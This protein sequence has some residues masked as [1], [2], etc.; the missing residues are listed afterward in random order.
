M[1]K[2]F[3]I[4]A[5]AIIAFVGTLITILGFIK[6][7]LG[8]NFNEPYSINV[9][10]NSSTTI[11]KGE[12]IYPEDKEYAKV[13][14]NLNKSTKSSLLTLLLKT[15]SVKYNI[16]YD[17]DKY[18]V[19]DTEMKTKNLV[20]ELIYNKLQ[21]IVVYEGKNTRVIPYTC[22]LFV[23]PINEKFEEIVV[24]NSYT[25]DSTL[26]ETEYKNNK[27]FVIKGNPKKIISYVKSI[28]K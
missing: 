11:K 1:K 16:E 2:I 13:I 9:F 19:Y 25:S 17:N 23:I 22:L 3:C 4:V 14:K 26:K 7:D 18:S 28:N 27:P 24:Y 8:F 6:K 15:G 12:S 5:V 20:I 21:N 10:Y